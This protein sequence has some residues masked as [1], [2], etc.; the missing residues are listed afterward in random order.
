[1]NGHRIE[2]LSK[3]GPDNGTGT[4]PTPDQLTSAAIIDL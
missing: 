2:T 3:E 1:M 4:E